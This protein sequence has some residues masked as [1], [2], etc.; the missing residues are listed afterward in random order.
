MVINNSSKKR[1]L[2]I[3]IIYFVVIIGLLVVSKPSILK[4]FGYFM[5]IILLMAV[6]WVGTSIILQLNRN[7][8][9][10]YI[11]NK[12]YAEA[13]K[14]V[15]KKFN[16]RDE[17]SQNHYNYFMTA[18]ECRDLLES[19]PK[20][21]SI[22]KTIQDINVH[23]NDLENKNALMKLSYFYIMAALYL[24]LYEHNRCCDELKEFG[25]IMEQIDSIQSGDELP[26]EKY[27][28]SHDLRCILAIVAFNLTGDIQY[29]NKELNILREALNNEYLT[30]VTKF[31]ISVFFACVQLKK[32]SVQKETGVLDEM[33]SNIERYKAYLQNLKGSKKN[34]YK[35]LFSLY[36]E[37]K[38][39]DDST[40]Y[41][42]SML[43]EMKR[44]K[45]T[46]ADLLVIVN[47]RKKS[48]LSVMPSLYTIPK[49]DN[50]DP[51]I[52]LMALTSIALFIIAYII[53]NRK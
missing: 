26:Q 28:Q 44:Y 23:L 49:K 22:Q 46:D 5:L 12:R 11:A 27:I 25:S 53:A 3:S 21:E 13:K 6:L 18:I 9:L 2:D 31:Y 34:C 50:I 4:W 8:L 40:V 1:K 52:L 10:R 15:H 16:K 7:R 39:L 17:L 32:Y 33:K 47:D 29:L 19:P 38:E 42:D 41:P 36:M 24:K 48:P 35:I 43:K 20:P 51:S 30:D 37:M 45:I 14:Y